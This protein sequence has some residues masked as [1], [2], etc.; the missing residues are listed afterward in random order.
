MRVVSIF[1]MKV[2]KRCKEKRR[3]KELNKYINRYQLSWETES[4]DLR[5]M[6]YRYPSFDRGWRETSKIEDKQKKTQKQYETNNIINIYKQNHPN[7][8]IHFH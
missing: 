1:Q 4:T 8:W 5:V 2:E 7:Q 3:N 6:E